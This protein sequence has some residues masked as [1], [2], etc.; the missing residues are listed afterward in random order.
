MLKSIRSIPLILV[1]FCLFYLSIAN[2]SYGQSL[3]K[4][5]IQL[6]WSHQFQ[7][8]G[9]YAAKE[10]G[11]YQDAGYDVELLEHD[12]MGSIAK[13]VTQ[14]S[15]DYGVN[16]SSLIVAKDRGL[17]V[18]IVAQI[19]QHSPVS[20]A[21]L[22]S[23]N[24][25]TPFELIGK[26][27]ALAPDQEKYSPIVAMLKQVS[28]TLS[29]YQWLPQHNQI[30]ALTNKNVDAIVIYSVNEPFTFDTNNIDTHILDPRDYGI[31]FYGDNLFTSESEVK[32]NPER[33]Q[34][35]RQ[36]TIKGW[37]YALRNKSKII[38]LIHKKYNSQAKSKAHLAFEADEISNIV[39]E[40]FIPIGSI[41]KTRMEK[42]AE[43]YH[44]LGML[45]SPMLPDNL[46][47]ADAIPKLSTSTPDAG[48]NT[49]LIIAM[50][51][52]S[53]VLIAIM[54]FMP[55]LIT[56]Q[57][58]AM[59]MASRKFP[60]IVHSISLFNIMIIFSVIYLTLQD[61]EESTQK[62]I[63]QNI[64]YVVEATS[65]RLNNWINEQQVQLQQISANHDFILFT[66][67]LI[68]EFEHSK[69]ISNHID[70]N[71]IKQLIDNTRLDNN[72][73]YLINSAYINIASNQ[74]HAIGQTNIIG[75]NQPNTLLDVF[76]GRTRFIAPFKPSIVATSEQIAPKNQPYNMFMATPVKNSQ[77]K[78]IAV[79][80]AKIKMTGHLSSIMQQGRIGQTG[81]SYLVSAQGEMLTKSRFASALKHSEY[82]KGLQQQGKSI[83]LKD[84]QQNLLE[85][86]IFKQDMNHKPYTTMASHLIAAAENIN[87]ST[88][89]RSTI[90]HNIQ[91]YHDY[92]GITVYGAWL[93]DYQ[94]GFG[95]ATE[96]DVDEAM[97]DVWL[98]RNKL[99][100][101]AL[102]TLLLTL[103]SNTFTITV[104][105]RS[106]KYMLRSKE[107]LEQIVEQRTQELQLRERAMWELYEN[108]PVAYATIDSKGHF[109]EHNSAFA[110]LFKRPREEFTNLAWQDFTDEAHHFH[111][112]FKTKSHK[113]ENEICVYIS[114]NQTIDALVSALPV[115]ND[116][117]EL[118]EVRLT[119]I[120]VTQK[121]ATQAQFNAL[122]A[123]APDAIL[124][125]DKHQEYNMVNC[126]V[127]NMFGYDK[128]DIIGNKV[129][130]LFADN[131]EVASFQRMLKEKV[132]T[133]EIIEITAKRKDG[134]E[135]FAEITIKS[136]DIHNDVFMIAIV[137]DISARKQNEEI[138]NGQILFQQALVDTIPYPIFVKGADARF[139][140]VNTAY[141]ETFNVRRV[142]I[143]GKTVLDL[144]YLP[145]EDRKAYQI[146]DT[147]VIASLGMVKKE[148]NLVYADGLE[149]NTV[150]W[151]KGFS[152]AD[153]SPAGLLG[154]FVDIS[155]QKMAELAMANA[156]SL[157]EDAVEA[158]S[159]FLA[160]M[161]HEIRTP[162]NAIIGMS[163]LALKT[164]LTPQQENYI[165][166]VNKAAASLLGIIN[167]ILDF[168]K[169]EA[170]K[171]D[172]EN[173]PFSLDDILD[174]LNHMLVDKLTEKQTELI[175]D[176]EKNVPI[177]LIGDPLRLGQILT[178]LG[179]NAA[180]FTE[181]G[182]VK[183]NIS[184]IDKL[185]DMIKL[186]FS[187]C[188]TGIGMTTEQLAKLFQSFN[189]ADASTTRKYGGTGLGLA[190]CKRLI[191]LLD[192]DIWVESQI[193]VG[194]QFYFT[195]KLQVQ[196]PA[197]IR[198]HRPYLSSIQGLQ[199]ALISDTDMYQSILLRILTSLGFSVTNFTGI[200]DALA[201]LSSGKIKFDTVLVDITA[202]TTLHKNL[203]KKIR[204]E[205][206][207]LPIL[208]VMPSNQAINTPML[209][210]DK[211]Y[212]LT[213]K[214]I[215]SSNL[216]DSLLIALGKSNLK[217][218]NYTPHHL[219]E[220]AIKHLQGAKLLLVEDNKINQE[221]ATELLT[222]NGIDVVVA[223]NGQE[224]ITVLNE[225]AFDG[226]LMDCQ[227]PIMD[228]YSATKLLR[229][230]TKFSSL[231]II[232]MTANV[233]AGDREKALQSGMNEH[234]GKP[235]N[236]QELFTKLS[237]WVTPSNPSQASAITSN[238]S[239]ETIEFP[240]LN[241]IN[242]D[243][244]LATVQGNKALYHHLLVRFRQDNQHSD[245]DIKKCYAQQNF[246]LLE[247]HA[248]SLKG[249]A[250]NI[251]ANALSL[252]SEKLEHAAQS[253]EV[254]NALMTDLTNELA[255][256]L[257]SLAQLEAHKT[258]PQ[259]PTLLS[260]KEKQALFTQLSHEV[261]NFDVAATETIQKLIASIVDKTQLSL[262][263]AIE[264]KIEYYEFDEAITLLNKI[265]TIE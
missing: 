83:P 207:I 97:Q 121:N 63:K 123:S 118:T 223:N 51:V 70:V 3:E 73:F 233:M 104:G 177:D 189:Q 201:S 45:E 57:R 197:Q 190:I 85:T 142:D 100:V 230:Q 234:I 90:A 13:I 261:E 218:I 250:G 211:F 91:G 18:V 185:D 140:N 131:H 155:E 52:A 164:A 127:L 31:D 253:G 15:A 217:N 9:Y 252:A 99:M 263:K 7:F 78:V 21:T 50:V 157:A 54:L 111:A 89:S 232:A 184:C 34:A 16:D 235:I 138:L 66:Q 139:I 2:N 93:W 41:E 108:A 6:N 136:V 55:K 194:S 146:E 105:Q 151:V 239:T 175:F 192:G 87:T 135:F 40:N 163:S 110:L 240:E 1:L 205:N 162:M 150:Y 216:L 115:Y 238:D 224:A 25:T 144:T 37:Q 19:F 117:H 225:Q 171:L 251:G 30:T 241:G 180:K 65:R 8:A 22:K 126:Q 43:L 74:K 49:S 206:P 122:M 188:D 219:E 64:T 133:K 76:S 46:L 198:L 75:S 243:M 29:S 244:G 17:P 169:I 14:G 262:M 153:G 183:I 119:L 125:I 210:N 229:Q 35:I 98:L 145:M 221:L 215:T 231:P 143:I 176:V 181:H 256:V 257:T 58:L 237:H 80:L 213:Y 12:G 72:D 154:T 106:T 60:F 228:G 246:K 26:R 20:L 84:P 82:F 107:D 62:N 114:P 61:N 264:K 128:D 109:I 166:K 103:T 161:S 10:Q 187:V 220:T 260:T 132:L 182:E 236:T 186:Q 94:H 167:D 196:S 202:E 200:E 95:I 191:E 59:F 5:T 179:S 32:N 199:I 147:E 116:E 81:E 149:H 248:H 71:N 11:Y 38:E 141:E 92:R 222:H 208:Q 165:V 130:F 170:N 47:L 203:I 77:G 174:N 56:K 69:N 195:V 172:I 124:M 112:L 247:H 158:K 113:F 68:R 42:L 168:S 129:E 33:V 28:P 148:L 242:L 120:D 178:N 227:M 27:I 137:R 24:I 23:A 101:I 214:P 255:L 226:V 159:N 4:V 156:K 209:Q 212:Y 134:S 53:L 48:R 86:P 258:P 44:Q 36:A 254:S 173:I 88:K 67:N 204:E 259:Q 39:L 160:N 79:L 152:K 245:S 193:G 96:I 265:N 249:V 102:I